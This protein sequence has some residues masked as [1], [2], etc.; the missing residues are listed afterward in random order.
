MSEIVEVQLRG[1]IEQLTRL[2]AELMRH[3][4]LLYLP[5]GQPTLMQQLPVMQERLDTLHDAVQTTQ[6]HL[7]ALDTAMTAQHTAMRD[8]LTALRL[9][10]MRAVSLAVGGLLVLQI[11]V[12]PVALK[13]LEKLLK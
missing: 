6:Q 1:I 3:A 10:L 4:H 2:E 7:D 8:Q 13:W 12:L 5:N 11:V 9:T